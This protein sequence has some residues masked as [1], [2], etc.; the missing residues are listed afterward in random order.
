MKKAVYPGTFDPITYGHL[1][2]IKR[3]LNLFDEL[4]VG[5]TTNPNK[6]S[7]FSLDER[8]QLAKEAVKDIPNVSVKSFDGLLVDFAGQ[9]GASIILRG[10]R[11]VSDFDREFQEATVNR[12][13]NTK[14]E[15]VFVMTSPRFFHLNSTAVKEIASMGGKI[16][17]F[18]AG[19]VEKALRKKFGRKK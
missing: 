6:K 15:T 10:L 9:E 14:I 2:V 19:P 1:D 11:E 4:V 13:L 5:I 3:G 8:V 16:N 12:K 17:C 7:L 18:V